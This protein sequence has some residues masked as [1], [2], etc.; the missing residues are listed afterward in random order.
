MMSI[1]VSNL[2]RE[3]E[4]ANENNKQVLRDFKSKE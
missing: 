3:K 2:Q 4:E 1:Q